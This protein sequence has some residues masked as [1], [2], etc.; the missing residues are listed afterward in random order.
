MKSIPR[1]AVVAAIA[2]AAGLWRGLTGSPDP[3]WPEPSRYLLE[4]VNYDEPTLPE[5][6]I[7]RVPDFDPRAIPAEPPRVEF[8]ELP[9]GAPIALEGK[10]VFPEIEGGLYWTAKLYVDYGTRQSSSIGKS[11]LVSHAEHPFR[12]EG[13]VPREPGRYPV[14][15]NLSHPVPGTGAGGGPPRKKAT[16]IICEGELVVTPGAARPGSPVPEGS[17]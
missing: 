3:E 17:S 6:P 9:P 15:V 13:F 16:T 11:F 2:V 10:F 12:I 8:P 5:A 1:W 14:W 7:V 4:T